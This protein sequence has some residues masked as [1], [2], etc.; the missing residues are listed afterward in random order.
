MARRNNIVRE[1]FTLATLERKKEK[2]KAE[3]EI[4]RRGD[5][6]NK[7]NIHVAYLVLAYRVYRG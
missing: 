3:R 5:E 6:R 2:K 1:G 4:C 7:Y